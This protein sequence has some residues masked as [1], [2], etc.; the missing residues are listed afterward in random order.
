MAKKHG[1]TNGTNGSAPAVAVGAPGD[2]EQ[3]VLRDLALHDAATAERT[4]DIA[5]KRT[6]L[7]DALVASKGQRFPGTITL[8]EQ[9]V[10][11]ER[12]L[13]EH[14]AVRPRLEAELG[15]ARAKDAAKRDA[16][17]EYLA[18]VAA[19]QERVRRVVAYVEGGE[20]EYGAMVAAMNAANVLGRAHAFRT[21]NRPP[22]VLFRKGFFAGDYARMLY[23]ALSPF[24]SGAKE[25]S[26][27]AS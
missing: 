1:S 21:F 4:T 3:L 22:D 17:P 6:E 20:E 5:A 8:T 12:E 11:L 18:H 26:R 2:H 14:V 13:A 7:A 19:M 25:A 10:V 16:E 27:S 24:M 23:A 9:L 15:P